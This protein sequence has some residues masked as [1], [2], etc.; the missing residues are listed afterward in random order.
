LKEKVNII[1]YHKREKCGVRKLSEVFKIGKTQAAEIVKKKEEL[2][3]ECHFN[4][5][6]QGIRQF[7]SVSGAVIDKAMIE[8]FS[9]IRSQ[10]VPVSGP[11]IQVKALEFAAELGITDFK[12]SNGWLER[13]RKRHGIKFRSICGESSSVNTETVAS[14]EEKSPSITEGYCPENILNADETGLFFC[15]LPDKMLCFKG[16]SCACGKVAKERLTVSLMR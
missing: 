5:N 1:E 9:K 10:S 16:K 4:G 8:W 7:L 2:I 3:K 11:M 6:E 12:A 15:A 13:F 14:W